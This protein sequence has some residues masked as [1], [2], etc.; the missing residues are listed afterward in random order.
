MSLEAHRSIAYRFFAEQDRL[1]GGP[2]AELCAPY[3]TAHLAENPP[4][5]YA[6]HQGFAKAFY[7]GFPDLRHQVELVV[8]EP[9][10]VAVRFTLHGTHTGDF[11]GIVA[12]GRQIMVTA[13]A[14]MHLDGGRVAALWA[15]FDQLGLVGQ[16]TSATAV[17]SE[18]QGI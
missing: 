1:R 6:G 5:D 4:M 8:A 12:T 10:Q 13:T 18:S 7:T 3:Y 11:A 2:A 9:E 16:L 17:T 15:E 14:M